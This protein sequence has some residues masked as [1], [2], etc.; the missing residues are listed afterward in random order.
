MSG[1]EWGKDREVLP[2]TTSRGGPL[3]SLAIRVLDEF[4]HP[5]ASSPLLL[6]GLTLELLGLCAREARN[7]SA[8]PPGLL[9]VRDRLTEHRT[10]AF[11]LADLAAEAGVPRAGWLAPSAGISAALSGRSRS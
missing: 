9:R 6:E 8:V 1:L 4:E 3:V 10:A 2:I 5:D 7:G 11:T